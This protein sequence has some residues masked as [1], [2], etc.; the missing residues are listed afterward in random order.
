MPVPVDE[1]TG[2]AQ[3]L[4]VAPGEQL[5]L[6]ISST[7][8]T[9]DVEVVRLLH[10]DDAGVGGPG[11]LEEVARE[12][13]SWRG[14][15][16]RHQQALAGS[17]GHLHDIPLPAD[18]T[19]VYFD[20]HLHTSVPLSPVGEQV[21]TE[22]TDTDS[23]GFILALDT[24]G[25]LTA[26][27][28]RSG[29]EAT[30][31]LAAPIRPAAWSHAQIWIGP[32]GSMTLRATDLDTGRRLE[33]S[34]TLTSGPWGPTS[35]D[36]T[37]AAT[38][39]LTHHFTGRLERPR[40][41]VTTDGGESWTTVSDVAFGSAPDEV[42]FTDR[43]SPDRVGTLRN[44]PARAAAGHGHDGSEID[45][46]MA[47]DLYDAVHFHDDDIVDLDWDST[48][49][50][51]VPAGA[52]P[53]FY[54]ATLS[55]GTRRERIPF[56]VRRPDQVADVVVLVPT[57]TYVA[58]SCSRLSARIDYE[59]MGLVDEPNPLH[60]LDADLARHPE[61]GSSTYDVHRDGSPVYY[62]GWRRPAPGFRPDHYLRQTAAPRHLGADLY[63]TAWLDRL[64]VDH[65]LVTDHDVHQRG[66]AALAGAKVLILATHPEYWTRQMLDG[67]EGFIAAGGRVMYLGGNGLYWVTSI[68]DLDPSVVEVRRGNAGTRSWSDAPGESVH[69]TSGEPGGL[70]RHRGRAPQKYVGVGM[71]SQGWGRHTPGYRL[72]PEAR[73]SRL[74]FMF[75][76][77]PRDGM[78]GEHGIGYGGAAGD[79]IDRCDP[80]LGTPAHAVRIATSEGLHSSHYQ[81]VVEDIEVTAAKLDGTNNPLVRSDIVFFETPAG[82]AVFSVGSIAYATALPTDDYDNDV[83][84]LTTNVLRRFLDAEP[85][86]WPDP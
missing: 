61:W 63:L 22:A 47:P 39:T 66:S 72:L 31:T 82:G 26:R 18:A 56:I 86:T 1:L 45:Y 12:W 73:S 84:R 24:Q 38:S 71:T 74:D 17:S 25:H 10:G 21:V 60:P 5:D 16:T 49:T 4:V 37:F 7:T 23:S 41:H 83:A 77:I 19:G 55:T 29:H 79:E 64:D 33:Q 9:V 40:L 35:L 59:A 28:R 81:L 20:L 42:S 75:D 80:S 85:F 34:T 52:R 46:R 6:R 3:E 36:L 11:L 67:L 30:V 69:S 57:A 50:A 43:C 51:Q 14:V 70:W 44:W 48:L 58:Y 78:F 13:E 32:G 54:A 68:S 8:S 15:A 27:V 76:G 2:Y 53:G 65:A 62:A